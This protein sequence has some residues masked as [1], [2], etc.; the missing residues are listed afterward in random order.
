MFEASINFLKNPLGGR[1]LQSMKARWFSACN[2]N[3]V[4]VY[5]R[6]WMDATFRGG[7]RLLLHALVTVYITREHLH[8]ACHEM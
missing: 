4:S 2:T 7:A 6:S 3:D 1:I 5:E 8:K